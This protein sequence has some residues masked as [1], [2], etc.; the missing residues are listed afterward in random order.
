MGFATQGRILHLEHG[1]GILNNYLVHVPTAR[2]CIIQKCKYWWSIDSQYHWKPTATLSHDISCNY[3][4]Y[5][6]TIILFCRQTSYLRS[7]A[8]HL[9]PQFSIRTLF[10]YFL[11]VICIGLILIMQ[12]SVLI[13]YF[14][15]DYWFTSKRTAATVLSVIWNLQCDF[16][17]V[18]S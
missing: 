10:L 12:H 2:G 16:F 5:Y 15:F 1:Y 8:C 3:F 18:F 17:R 9:F 14:L 4:N 13:F 11:N 7:A 6:F